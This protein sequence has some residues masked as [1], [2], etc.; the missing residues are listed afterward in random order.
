MVSRRESPGSLTVAEVLARAFPDGGGGQNEVPLHVIPQGAEPRW[1]IVGDPRPAAA[2]LRSWRPFK[3]GT[4]L[5]WSAVVA[6]AS[7]R[8][9]ARLP[10]VVTSRVSIHPAYWRRFLPDWEDDW[11]LVLHIGNPSHTRKATVFFAGQGGRCK[12]AAKVP[13]CDGAAQA[14]LNEA[15]VLGKLGNSDYHP[16]PLSEDRE[17][18]IAA[19]SWL[20]GKPVGRKLTSAHMELLG[21]FAVPGATTRIS[22]RREA[23]AAELESADLPFD[24]TVMARA[25]DLLDDDRQLPAF[26]EHRD[27]A[28]WNLKRLPG[29]STGAIDWEWAVLRSLPCQDIFRYFYIQDA[30][31]NGPG[32]VWGMLNRHPL[33]QAHLR[34]FEIPAESVA[35]LAMHYQLRVLVSDWKSGNA[36]LAEYEFNQIS[37]LVAVKPSSAMAAFGRSQ[38][39]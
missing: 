19:Q 14:I 21:R 17:K 36:G 32:D 7:V 39:I 13:L 24:R 34:R 38:M 15:D 18:G 4:R 35:A 20:D 33:V 6:A 10:G 37:K 29:G 27:F 2:V 16:S 28:P 23:I 11:T 31:F 9:L 5:R 3:M 8:A 22:N 25:L 1:I 26:V 30:L 12:A